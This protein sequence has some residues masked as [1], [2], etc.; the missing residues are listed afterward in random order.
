MRTSTPDDHFVT[1]LRSG[2][3]GV[4]RAQSTRS[5]LLALLAGEPDV[6]HSA[7]GA[8]GVGGLELHF[9]EPRETLRRAT[10]KFRGW[11]GGQPWLNLLN[12]RWLD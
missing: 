7:S 9:D 6:W 2:K 11:D 5:E 10:V 1:S 4:L 8:T 3:V 12:V